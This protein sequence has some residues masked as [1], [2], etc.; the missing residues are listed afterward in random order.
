[1]VPF[2]CSPCRALAQMSI[3]G[4]VTLMVGRK[5]SASDPT[6]LGL[7]ACPAWATHPAGTFWA[8][9]GATVLHTLLHLGSYDAKQMDL[10]GAGHH[11]PQQGPL[12]PCLQAS[13]WRGASGDPSTSFIF[14]VPG[15]PL[16]DLLL[17]KFTF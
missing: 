16:F 6:A 9:Q 13:P 17:L 2:G 14:L 7:L 4:S 12:S 11:P 1:M 10:H 8:R 3:C 5:A 15:E